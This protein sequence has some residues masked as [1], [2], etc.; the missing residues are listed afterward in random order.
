MPLLEA[1]SVCIDVGLG[2]FIGGIEIDCE[3]VY[4][5]DSRYES[6]PTRTVVARKGARVPRKD[7][8]ARGY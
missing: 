5:C 7:E 1:L 2:D 6:H 3:L 8:A 4:I